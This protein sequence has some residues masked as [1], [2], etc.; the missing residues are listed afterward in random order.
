MQDVGGRPKGAAGRRQTRQRRGMSNPE[1]PL[2][3]GGRRREARRLLEA[4]FGT[5]GRKTPAE[6]EL[7]RKTRKAEGAL[8]FPERGGASCGRF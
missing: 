4:P 3:I 6:P 7:N 1:R 2:E 5:Y 8:L